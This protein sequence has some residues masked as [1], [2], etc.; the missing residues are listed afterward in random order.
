MR[1]YIHDG[2]NAEGPCPSTLI[3]EGVGEHAK[4]HAERAY[5]NRGAQPADPTNCAPMKHGLLIARHSYR[6]FTLS[7]A[8]SRMDSKIAA[9]SHNG[10]HES[11]YDIE[12]HHRNQQKKFGRVEAS[13]QHKHDK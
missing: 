1:V 9:G 6:P 8:N 4:A 11:G 5:R 12:E 13:E 3:E 7:V 10:H 2:A